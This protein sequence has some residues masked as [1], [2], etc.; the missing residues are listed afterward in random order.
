MN[1]TELRDVMKYLQPRERRQILEYALMLYRMRREEE[2]ESK[3][4][5]AVNNLHPSE[6]TS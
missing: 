3:K 1:L 4:A 5:Q 6:A 2:A